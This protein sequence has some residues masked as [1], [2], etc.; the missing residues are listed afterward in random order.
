VPYSPEYRQGQSN[1]GLLEALARATSGAHLT[2]PAEA[3]E[4][5]LNGVS[6]AQEIALALLLLAL[7]LLPLDIAVRRLMLRREDFTAASSWLRGVFGR[8]V[9]APAVSAPHIDELRRA[10]SRAAQRIDRR[11]PPPPP[12]EPSHERA[13]N[14]PPAAPSADDPMERL[15]AARE[16]ARRRA[17]GEE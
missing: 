9:P 2:Q 8:P 17:R 4:H 12:A 7:L 15:R 3:F 10:K 11:P 6:R 5:T 13:A 1:P 14:K 16:R